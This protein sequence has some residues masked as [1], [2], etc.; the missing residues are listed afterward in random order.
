[1]SANTAAAESTS[2][3]LHSVADSTAAETLQSVADSTTT[4]VALT[5]I[6]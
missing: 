6:S 4:G 1:M 5:E 2:E 3:S